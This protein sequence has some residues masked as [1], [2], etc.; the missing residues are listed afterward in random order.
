M[1]RH[2]KRQNYFEKLGIDNGSQIQIDD[3]F[4]NGE[5]R[6]PRNSSRNSLRMSGFNSHMISSKILVGSITNDSI[7]QF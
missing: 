2:L 7:V 1:A 4:Q 6:E 3:Y 5:K